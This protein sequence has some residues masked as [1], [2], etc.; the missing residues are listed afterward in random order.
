MPESDNYRNIPVSDIQTDILILDK[1]I[2]GMLTG[3]REWI[4]DSFSFV[5][6]TISDGP[7]YYLLLDFSDNDFTRQ[8]S[9]TVQIDN[10]DP[11]DLLHRDNKIIILLL[12]ENSKTIRIVQKK[13]SKTL[14][15]TFDLTALDFE[16]E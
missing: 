9:I 3:F 10:D 11:V 5:D 16:L 8:D 13:L 1:S 12:S 4:W 15:Q 2:S 6:G 14:V 7:Y